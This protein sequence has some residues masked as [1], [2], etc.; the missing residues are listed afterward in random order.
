M[1]EKKMRCFDDS[2]YI[3][4]LKKMCSNRPKIGKW[5]TCRNVVIGTK[6]FQNIC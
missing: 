6:N 4:R 3:L 2:D 5:N 1:R